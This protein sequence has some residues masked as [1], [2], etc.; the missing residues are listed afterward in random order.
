MTG[1]GPLLWVA[2]DCDEDYEA[3]ERMLRRVN[4]DT[5][6]E[7]YTRGEHLIAALREARPHGGWPALLLLDLNLPTETG[8]QTLEQIRGDQRLRMLPVVV[9]SGSRRQQDIDAAY[10]AGANAYAAKPVDARELDL[11][12]RSL[13]DW[14]GR[15]LPP[16]RPPLEGAA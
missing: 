10:A 9:L 4:A 5:R 1:P 15:T 14:W 11:L 12:L 8:L 6:L 2:E 16:S 13:L 3:L 7:R